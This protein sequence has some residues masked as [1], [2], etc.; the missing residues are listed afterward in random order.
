LELAGLS[1]IKVTPVQAQRGGG[2]IDPTHLKPR[3]QKWLGGQQYASATSLPGQTGY[4][5]YGRLGG[6]RSRSGR[7]R[8]ISTVSVFDPRSDYGIEVALNHMNSDE[9]VREVFQSKTGEKEVGKF[10]QNVRWKSTLR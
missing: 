8:K 7:V 9:N 1:H 3:K 4:P 6:P 5:F 10:G 2:S